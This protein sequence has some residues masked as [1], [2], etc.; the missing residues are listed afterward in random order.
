MISESTLLD[1][2]SQIALAPVPPPS[3]PFG[4]ITIGLRWELTVVCH[5][6]V[7]RCQIAGKLTAHAR[8][9]GLA[10]LVEEPADREK[11]TWRGQSLAVLATG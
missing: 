3:P 5:S 10:V 8:W 7:Y 2:W 4:V 1:I 9:P 11:L 6:T